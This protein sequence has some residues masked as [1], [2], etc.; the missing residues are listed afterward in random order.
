[1]KEINKS[2]NQKK[3]QHHFQSKTFRS[4]HRNRIWHL[5]IVFVFRYFDY[6]VNIKMYIV[7]DEP[8]NGQNTR[9]WGGEEERRFLMILK[10]LKHCCI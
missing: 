2:Q 5:N 1:M 7:G 4:F 8:L 9:W 6:L 10:I 3:N